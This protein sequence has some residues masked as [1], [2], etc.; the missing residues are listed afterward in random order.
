[1]DG[2]RRQKGRSQQLKN[3]QEVRKANRS[4]ILSVCPLILAL[5]P[6]IILQGIKIANPRK[7]M[8]INILSNQR[9]IHEPQIAHQIPQQNPIPQTN[10]KGNDLR[11]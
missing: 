11:I 6:K 4:H 5:S 1:M 3:R 9:F 7:H 10:Q 8:V 2:R